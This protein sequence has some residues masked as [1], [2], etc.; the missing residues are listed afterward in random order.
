MPVLF[1]GSQ[2]ILAPNDTVPGGATSLSL[3]MWI[4]IHSVSGDQ[5]S[6]PIFGKLYHNPFT[7]RSYG[8]S[9]GGLN[10]YRSVTLS[11]GS[12]SRQDVLQIG[13]TY[14]VVVVY[15]GGFVRYY[16]NGVQMAA[17]ATTAS[18]LTTSAP[19]H[20]WRVG[21]TGST[22]E[23]DDVCCWRN[24]AL[25]ALEIKSLRNRS[26]TP[27][28]IAPEFHELYWTLD[29]T[30]G[31]V[32]NK[33]HNAVKTI[34]GTSNRHASSVEGSPIYTAD[35]LVYVPPAHV[36]QAYI[37]E[38]GKTL[39]ITFESRVGEPAG[40]TSQTSHP[41]VK[42]NGGSPVSL[43]EPGCIR[44]TNYLVY[45]LPF[46][47]EPTDSL[48]FSA[49]DAWVT[50]TA[51]ESA[52]VIEAPVTTETSG[53][54][55]LPPF[56]DEPKSLAIGMNMREPLYYSVVQ[57]YANMISHS[58]IGYATH[59]GSPVYSTDAKGNLTS[60][61]GGTVRK[62]LAEPVASGL[63]AGATDKGHQ[64]VGNGEIRVL[65][66]GADELSLE[67]AAAR[68]TVTQTS[69]TRTYTTNNL[70]VYNNTVTNNNFASTLRLIYNGPDIR[71][72]RV[73]G[74]GVPENWTSKF[75]PEFLRMASDWKTIRF[76]DAMAT[77]NSNYIRA[78]DY[79]SSEDLSYG[80]GRGSARSIIG[81]TTYN[82]A[83]LDYWSNGRSPFLVTT[84]APHGFTTGQVVNFKNMS[85]NVQFTGGISKYLNSHLSHI[86]VISP[87][88]FGANIWTGTGAPALANQN[89]TGQVQ[90]ELRPHMPI[91]DIIEC[92]EMVG[93][94]PWICIPHLMPDEEVRNLV[95]PF[96][97]NLSPGRKLYIEYSNECWNS[98][99]YFQQTEFCDGQAKL[100]GMP[101]GRLWYVKRTA[102]V[103]AAATAEYLAQG[104]PASDIVRVYAGQ[105]TNTNLTSHLLQYARNQNYQLDAFAVAP[106][107]SVKPS[108]FGAVY[109]SL[110]ID[111]LMDVGDLYMVDSE[112]PKPILQAHRSL[113]NQYFPGA[114]L[115]CYEGGLEHGVGGWGSVAKGASQSRAW[116]RHPRIRHYLRRYLQNLQDGGVSLFNQFELN[117][118][119][120]GNNP[121]Y[122]AVWGVYPAAWNMQDGLGDGSDGKFD[123]RTG[124]DNLSQIV[125]VLGYTLRDWANRLRPQ[126]LEERKARNN[127]VRRITPKQMK[128]SSFRRGY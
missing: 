41:T 120:A 16:L 52:E 22:I 11:S 85:G 48:V 7:I 108:G 39:I 87:T 1:S 59:T 114:S 4:R 46:T 13:I 126:P 113:L 54:P 64:N 62:T 30:A 51:G 77:N 100:A 119:H 63:M 95:R 101:D 112:Y 99:L 79:L 28:E 118:Y 26:V 8:P 20:T 82:E 91:A 27:A 47:V 124:Y 42:L 25:S 123:N 92:C 45:P 125:S 102:E 35:P 57:T 29:G 67:G 110:D 83:P 111:Q 122:G 105:Y 89:I 106:Y 55:I 90:A 66:D 96:A 76:M 97:Q 107:L 115:V 60:L 5:V 34:T 36:R 9:G 78:S 32:V 21:T 94:D 73:F 31:A 19:N 12:S 128:R 74:P 24:Y 117:V 3:Q 44:A 116:S 58:F 65:W 33:T 98:A 56:V 2:G 86:R 15:G 38:S 93:A 50:T 18:S 81:I 80:A 109:D 104:R 127:P 84:S 23:L 68:N 70:R 88:Q 10:V 14:H 61:S 75:H 121:N 40:I 6:T 53:Q 43:S 103:H 69:Y 72:V 49:D 37:G 17:T 71:N